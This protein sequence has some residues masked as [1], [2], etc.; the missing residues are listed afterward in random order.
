MGR[1]KLEIKKIEN[2]TNRQVTYSKRRTG[3]VKKAYELSTL[4]DIDIALIMFSPSGKLTQ[5]ATDMRVEDVILR[6]ANVSEAERSKRKME[7]WEQLSRAIKKLKSETDGSQISRNTIDFNNLGMI[8]EEIAR[9]QLENEQLIERFKFYQGDTQILEH[10]SYEDLAKL[11]EEL[12]T[13]LHHIR[14]RKHNM[15]VEFCMRQKQTEHFLPQQVYH[16]PLH[17]SGINSFPSHWSDR[18]PQIIKFLTE[19]TS[20]EG[21]STDTLYFEQQNNIPYQTTQ[22]NLFGTHGLSFDNANGRGHC[23]IGDNKNPIIYISHNPNTNLEHS[24]EQPHG[25]EQHQREISLNWNLASHPNNQMP[26]L[27]SSSQGMNDAEDES[28]ES[29]LGED[30]EPEDK[31]DLDNVFHSDES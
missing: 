1:V 20:V 6:Y 3:L 15:D 2:A 17:A 7:N 31:D 16:L 10:L 5:Y 19:E 28:T 8:Q 29:R 22:L 30:D 4:C 24:M 21:S 9:L 25:D 11:E 27:Y 23:Y 12:A 26:D 13:T 14:I 18:D